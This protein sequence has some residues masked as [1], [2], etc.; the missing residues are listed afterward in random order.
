[1]KKV[2]SSISEETLHQFLEEVFGPINRMYRF[3]AESSDK[4]TKKE[5]SRRYNSYS[6]E[7]SLVTAAMEVAKEGFIYMDSIC[8]PIIVEKF[9]KKIAPCG[10]IQTTSAS[11]KVIQ[12]SSK[13]R[14]QT[15][16]EP[17]T[18]F[19][20]EH[21]QPHSGLNRSKPMLVQDQGYHNVKPTKKSYHLNREIYS[22]ECSEEDLSNYRVR[23]NVCGLVRGLNVPQSHSGASPSLYARCSF[24]FLP[25]PSFKF[26]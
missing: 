15:P 23:I 10:D 8:T 11:H 7:F 4:A 9:Q 16:Q 24:D 12:Q 17:R 20:A 2:P 25:Q 19:T 5:K 18:L 13:A 6:V 3:A 21:Q 14:K 1:L 22:T 26:Y